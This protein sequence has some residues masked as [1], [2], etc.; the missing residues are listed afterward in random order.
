MTTAIISPCVSTSKNQITLSLTKTPPPQNWSA[1]SKRL[2]EKKG[3]KV[4]FQKSLG[5]WGG[6]ERALSGDYFMSNCIAL[7]PEEEIG[8]YGFPGG[9]GLETHR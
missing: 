8:G 3:E 9:V 6:R 5:R 4:G 2:G 1:M 7:F